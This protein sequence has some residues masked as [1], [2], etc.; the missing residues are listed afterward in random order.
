MNGLYYYK[1]LPVPTINQPTR[2]QRCC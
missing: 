2:K 1:S